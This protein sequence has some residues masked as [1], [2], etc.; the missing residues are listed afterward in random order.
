MRL[1]HVALGCLGGAISIRQLIVHNQVPLGYSAG[2]I[3]SCALDMSVSLNHILV[4]ISSHIF[5]SFLVSHMIW[6]VSQLPL[7]QIRRG[8]KT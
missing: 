1:V 4:Y 6:A 5:F 3:L 8:K 2:L 7:P